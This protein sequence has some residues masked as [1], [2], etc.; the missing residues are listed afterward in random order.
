MSHYYSVAMKIAGLFL[1]ISAFGF[2]GKRPMK[3]EFAELRKS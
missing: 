1:L 2:A 3:S